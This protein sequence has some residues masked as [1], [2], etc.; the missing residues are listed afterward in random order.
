MELRREGC[1]LL[2]TQS[3]QT[4]PAQT[5]ARP[6]FST[7]QS[8]SCNFAES[9]SLDL[10]IGG[11]AE[12][13]GGAGCLGARRVFWVEGTGGAPGSEDRKELGYAMSEEL[14]QASR[15]TQGV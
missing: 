1:G 8:G 15:G 7:P 5:L 4:K 6:H 10:S 11:Q 13:L 3:S 9:L 2:K 12:I 14:G